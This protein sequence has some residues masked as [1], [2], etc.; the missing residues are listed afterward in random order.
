VENLLIG[1]TGNIETEQQSEVL[2]STSQSDF[3]FSGEQPFGSQYEIV[4]SSRFHHDVEIT[5]T[6]STPA[7][8]HR[9]LQLSK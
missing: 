7:R 9:R 3:H 6:T 1:A 2:V 8:S 4:S 5:A